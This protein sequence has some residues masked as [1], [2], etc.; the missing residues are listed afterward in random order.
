MLAKELG[1]AAGDE[2]KDLGIAATRKAKELGDRRRVRRAEKQ[3]ATDA[4]TRLALEQGIDLASIEGSG[5]DGRITV[6]DVRSAVA[7]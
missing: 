2:A 3:N 4:A 5:S 6:Q 1:A 7:D